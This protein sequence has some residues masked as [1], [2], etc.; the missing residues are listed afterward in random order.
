[1]SN[2]RLGLVPA[3]E[4]LMPQRKPPAQVADDP[5]E[6]GMA[7]RLIV[8]S[9]P[10]RIASRR[11]V[12]GQYPGSIE[13]LA[14]FQLLGGLFGWPFVALQRTD[15]VRSG[16]GMGEEEQTAA[17]LARLHA[18][19]MRI[20]ERNEIHA[21]FIG[22]SGGPAVTSKEVGDEAVERQCVHPVSV[23]LSRWAFPRA[24]LDESCLAQITASR[25]CKATVG[26]LLVN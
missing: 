6:F 25:C 20:V 1:M 9:D 4:N 24:A 8:R 2:H 18:K 7:H 12:G 23:T 13:I 26:L 21:L 3:G 10:E 14:D 16:A 15:G 11:S 5:C 17:R 22:Q 19:P